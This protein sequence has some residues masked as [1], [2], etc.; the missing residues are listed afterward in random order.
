[1]R[2]KNFEFFVN[3]SLSSDLVDSIRIGMQKLFSKG[4]INIEDDV[5]DEELTPELIESKC[6][7][8]I[9][10]KNIKVFFDITPL[11]SR[12]QNFVG[13][14][15]ILF[16]VFKLWYRKTFGSPYEQPK[17]VSGIVN[18]TGFIFSDGQVLHS[19]GAIGVTF[20]NSYREVITKNPSHY[21]IVEIPNTSEEDVREKGIKLINQLQKEGSK[22]TYNFSGIFRQLGFPESWIQKFAEKGFSKFY[23][24]QL[25][26]NLLVRSKTFS[27]WD[28][29]KIFQYEKDINEGLINK[30][31][32]LNPNSVMDLVVSK[33]GKI[34]PYV[35]RVGGKTK[36]FD[37]NP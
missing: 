30:Y 25:V 12:R 1:M 35:C 37:F 21:I 5:V 7:W 32:Q 4:S 23:C 33:G 18:H 14:S 34:V 3:E 8:D 19:T 27:I 6:V 20:D 31:D 29:K 36:K 2:I 22:N 13:I 17:I 15:I 16:G 11:L 28:L 24:S 26:A 9:S 10:S